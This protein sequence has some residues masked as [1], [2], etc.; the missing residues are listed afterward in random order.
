MD[1]TIS[2]LNNE[3]MRTT[4]YHNHKENMAW[5]ATALYISGA[6]TL[7]SYINGSCSFGDKT[8]VL[9]VALVVTTCAGAFIKW[10]FKKRRVAAHRVRGLIKSIIPGKKI[11]STIASIMFGVSISSVFSLFNFYQL[12]NLPDWT[13][14]TNW[15]ILIG[16]L[17]VGVALLI[18]DAQQKEIIKISSDFI[19][20]EMETIEKNFDKKLSES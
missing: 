11:Y 1:N 2:W 12:E 3:I 6:I 9:L 13:L 20:S 8:A 19:L 17:V 5:V 4:V 18:I 14:P 10:Q 15:T 16:S 7:G